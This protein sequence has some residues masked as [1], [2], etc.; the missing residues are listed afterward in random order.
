M[1]T[2]TT[3]RRRGGR[4]PRVVISADSLDHLEGLAEGA[5]SRQPALADRL[6][7]ELG[8]ARIVPEAKLPADVVAMGRAVTYRDETTGQE[9]T[10]TP[11]YPEEADIAQGRISVLT[12]IGIALLGLAEGAAFSWEARDGSART[13]TVVRVEPARV[14]QPSDA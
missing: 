10:V 2:T 5:M 3:P 1:T 6:L 12:P 8:R 7:D 13:L 14:T 9:K 11:V 4:K